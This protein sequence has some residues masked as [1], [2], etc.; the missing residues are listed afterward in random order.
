MLQS[1][2]NQN[3]ELRC[4]V[5]E[6]NAQSERTESSIVTLNA[7]QMATK[8]L[9]HS[10]FTAEEKLNESE[11]E[12]LIPYR[13]D[14]SIPNWGTMHPFVC[15][16][17][18]WFFALCYV[19][20]CWKKGTSETGSPHICYESIELD[21]TRWQVTFHQQITVDMSRISSTPLLQFLTHIS[22]NK[23]LGNRKWILTKWESHMSS[24][25]SIAANLSIGL[26]FT[27]LISAKSCFRPSNL[28]AGK[29]NVYKKWT[30]FDSQIVQSRQQVSVWYA[31]FKQWANNSKK[32]NKSFIYTWYVHAKR[33]ELGAHLLNS[34]EMLMMILSLKRI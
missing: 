7:N 4:F 9:Y 11:K 23:Q 29:S 1:S 12:T 30:H 18:K 33:T 15:V 16:G 3:Q 32:N 2:Q 31:R 6:Q 34:A 22:A 20:W 14:D 13:Y 27:E 24:N 17:H 5:D 25:T 28:F 19:F 8:K 26:H 21:H 10:Y